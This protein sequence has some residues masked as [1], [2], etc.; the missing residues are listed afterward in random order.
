MSDREQKRAQFDTRK[1]PGRK[2]LL[3]LLALVVVAA[4][5]GFAWLL[6]PGQMTG[7]GLVEAG[8]DGTV[9][10]AKA[11]FADGKARFYRYQGQHGAIDFFLVQSRDGV[12]RA[13][14]DSC[15]VCYKE[16]KGY[17]QEGAEMICN[18]CDQRFK[19]NL[20]NVVKG[21]CNPAPLERRQVGDEVVIAAAAIEK[22]AG[23]FAGL[24]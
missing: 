24:N 13:A 12:I 11:E 14:F 2:L 21:G 1:T 18:N 8:S 9:R 22:G 20:V 15:D 7:P 4:A 10:F 16:L 3:P 19:T 17:R 6:L 5:A 23:Y